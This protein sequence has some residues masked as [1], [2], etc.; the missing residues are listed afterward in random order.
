LSIHLFPFS[1]II[2]SSSCVVYTSTFTIPE[3]EDQ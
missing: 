3:E 1:F 2:L